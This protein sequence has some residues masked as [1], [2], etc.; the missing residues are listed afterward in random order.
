M[1]A[2]GCHVAEDD[3]AYLQQRA[4]AELELAQRSE[5]PEVTAAHY[6]LAEA[7]LDRVTA[8]QAGAAEVAGSAVEAAEEAVSAAPG[9]AEGERRSRA[10]DER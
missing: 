10:D 3:L 2:K 8:L 5:A 7:Y 9:S 4:E 6:K 1:S